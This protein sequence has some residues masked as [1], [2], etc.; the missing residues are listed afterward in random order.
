MAP[1]WRLLRILMLQEGATWGEQAT[2]AMRDEEVPE[3]SGG[4]FVETSGARAAP[5][6]DMQIHVE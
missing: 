2:E 3:E 4:P 5:A 1:S 6:L